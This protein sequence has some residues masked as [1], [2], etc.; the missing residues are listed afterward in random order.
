VLHELLWL[1]TEAAKR[2]PPSHPA[3]AA[4]LA[5]EIGALDLLVR[6]AA[7]AL[8]ALDPHPHREL[9]HALL[10]RIGSALG[11]RRNARALAVLD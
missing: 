8:L 9:S 6:A 4:D 10:R 7:P 5:R 2:F 11:G 3:L 1:L